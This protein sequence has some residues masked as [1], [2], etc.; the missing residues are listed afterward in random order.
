MIIYYSG[1]SANIDL[2]ERVLE[3]QK[4]GVMLTYYEIYTKQR[5]TINRLER[6]EQR[7]LQKA[8]MKGKK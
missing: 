4:P 8:K 7:I 6:H 2:P 5:G 3:K 1:G